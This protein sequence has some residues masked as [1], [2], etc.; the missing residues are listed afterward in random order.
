MTDSPDFKLVSFEGLALLC[1]AFLAVITVSFLYTCVYNLYFHPLRHIPGP[2]LA[3]A[4]GFPYVY[5]VRTGQIVKW[6]KAQHEKYG[7]VVRVA[8][9]EV[10]FIS[11]ETAWPDIY[12]FRTGKYKGTGS[13]MKDRT[14]YPLP[15]NGVRSIISTDEETHSRMRR[16]FSHLFSEKAL[17]QQEPL[18]R[19]YVDLL[20]QRMSEHASQGKTMDFVRWYNFA[21]FDIIADLSFS[22]PLYCL[23]DS[24]NHTWITLVLAAV[25]ATGAIATR[26]RFAFARFYDGVR[27]LFQDK[28]KPEKMRANF[29]HKASEQVQRRLDQLEN[30]GDDGKPDFFGQIVRNQTS[31][32][33]KLS[34][35]EMD[36]NAVTFL[37][38]GS[39]TTATTLAGF[40]WLV[41]QNPSVHAKLVHEL[42][43]SFTSL[44]D[45]NIE[46]AGK[47]EY[48]AACIQETLR[49]YPPVA[50]GFPR[51]V[52]E[53]GSEISGHYI[54]GGTS[55][56]VSQH[57][58]YHSERNFK[59]AEKFVPER[60]LGTGEYDVDKKEAFNPFSFGP[61]NCIGKNLAWAELRLITAA[62]FFA[63]DLEL[64]DKKQD[65]L[66]EQEVH[67]LWKK[68]QLIVKLKAVQ[69]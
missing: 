62:V 43:S 1:V 7:E 65:W 48:L 64:V 37:V 2:L 56:Y 11:A 34:R 27:N 41:L 46:S 35:P 32:E 19:S 69:E 20:V 17:R 13:Y 40:T 4:T 67:T 28:K 21:T 3:R 16:N 30:D 10:S 25:S 23:R 57:A 24:E 42:R 60:W 31:S 47:L 22:E 49:V 58:T 54:P 61:R 5:N 18:I 50:T 29:Y 63:F 15:V 53:G 36:T 12:G 68:P 38:A 39:E 45:I 9:T 44:G 59:D 8:P 66:G 33:K 6:I 14:W 51:V 52:P 26:N 55:V